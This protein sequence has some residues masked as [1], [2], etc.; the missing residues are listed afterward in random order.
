MPNTEETSQIEPNLPT[1]APQA[2][3]HPLDS[4]W[5]LLIDQHV[6]GPYTGHE[7]KSYAG[8]GRVTRDTQVTRGAGED[9]RTAAATPALAAIFQSPPPPAASAIT[10]AAGATVVHVNN[11]IAAPAAAP[12]MLIVSGD[13]APKSAGVALFLSFLLCGVGQMYCGKVGKGVLMLLG[14]VLLWFV[15]LGWI[16]WIWS[17]ID[18]YSTAKAMNLRYQSLLLGG[19]TQ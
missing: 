18:A 9:W 1:S 14:S 7:I 5:Y 11:T 12:A 13:A 6:H 2:P 10:A 15:F 19:R 8:E 3:P 16:V 4:Q 17:M